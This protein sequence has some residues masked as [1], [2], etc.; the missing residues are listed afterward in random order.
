MQKTMPWS[1]MQGRTMTL[2]TRESLFVKN[3][4]RISS[5]RDLDRIGKGKYHSYL[6]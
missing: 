1:D 3:R 6:G 4:S 5:R 2:L